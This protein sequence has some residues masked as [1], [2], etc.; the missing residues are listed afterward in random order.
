MAGLSIS[1]LS[2]EYV[3]VPVRATSGGLPYNPTA[4]AV[5]M[6]FIAGWTEPQNSDWQPASWAWTTPVTGTWY[7]AQCLVGPQ[8]GGFDLAIGTYNVWVKITDNPAVP[9]RNTGT[10]TITP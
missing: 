10:L 5:Q 6:A 8:N 3:E 9:V 4:D 2:T 1:A 7:A